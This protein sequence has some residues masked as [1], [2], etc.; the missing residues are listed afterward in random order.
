MREQLRI[1]DHA[2]Q[3][4]IVHVLIDRLNA[5]QRRLCGNG[6]PASQ[7]PNAWH[8]DLRRVVA[9]R[10]ADELHPTDA[11]FGA[12]AGQFA[13]TLRQALP[14]GA[15]EG[16]HK[17]APLGALE[18]ERTP[19]L[20]DDAEAALADAQDMT[21]AVADWRVAT[22]LTALRDKINA[23]APRRSRAADG[24]IGDAMHRTRSSDHNPWVEDGRLGVVT[25]IDIT[26]DPGKGCSAEKLARSLQAMRDPR[27]KYV[28][29]NRRIMNARAIDGAAPWEWRSYNGAN[30]HK[31]HLHLSVRPEKASFDSGA[32]WQVTV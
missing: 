6:N 22:C 9:G 27:V 2:L 28:I 32:E 10:W 25:A 23:L 29:W 30:P 16:T 14:D 15:H 7:Y 21:E 4:Q 1:H 12:V 11:G 18:Q 26:D 19:N 20:G 3:A 5:L 13:A 24:T 31:S 17:H 8:V